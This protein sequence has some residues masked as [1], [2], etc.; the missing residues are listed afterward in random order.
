MSKE[1]IFNTDRESSVR[2]KIREGVNIIA[3][4]VKVTLGPTGRVVI[5]ER[6]Y[7][8]PVIT[9]DGVTV[10]RE[11]DL[12][13]PFMNMGAKMVRQ[14][15]AETA[16][17]AGDGTTTATVLAEAIFEEGIKAVN[18]GSNPQEIKRGIELAV[19]A[20][21]NALSEAASPVAE[22]EQIKQVAVCSSNQDE[23]IGSLIAE[24]MDKVGRDGV[25]TIEE[26]NTLETTVAIIDGLQFPRGYMSPHFVTDSTTLDCN[27]EDP[28]I[29]VMD[30]KLADIKSLLKV[31][32]TG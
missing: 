27:Y 18:A 30:D 11:V 22:L 16:K 8:D 4:A 3:K 32:E 25:I 5:F 1:I 14:A 26:G 28:N 6:E 12:K 21:V 17:N 10:A 31:L 15:A 2:D 19:E 7:G 29:L 9:K 13:D 24:A 20:I 23:R